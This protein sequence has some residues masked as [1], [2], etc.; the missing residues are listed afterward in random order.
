MGFMKMMHMQGERQG[1]F[2]L[3]GDKFPPMEVKTT[4]GMIKLPDAYAGKWVVLF[5][6]PGDFT[7]VCTTEF[8][9]FEKKRDE[10][11]KLNCELIGLSIDQ[12]FSH[13]KWTEW[14]KEKLG[15]QINFP[16]IADDSGRVASRLGMLHPGKGT[17]TV[18]AVF[19]IDAEGTI[20]M[21]SSFRRPLT[22]RP[23][24]PERR[25]EIWSARTGGSAI[26]SW[27]NS[28]PGL[29]YQTIICSARQSRAHVFKIKQTPGTFGA[30]A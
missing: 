22:R 7:P 19:I 21:R 27:A 12:V 16:I 26:R 25:A 18:R 13:M 9:S 20:R 6:H 8:V 28:C 5:S 1:S 3:I 29:S 14:I 11:E 24:P 4:H 30:A 23:P 15:V 17:N 2:P 10:F